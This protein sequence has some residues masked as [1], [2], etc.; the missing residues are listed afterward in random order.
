MCIAMPAWAIDEA[1][2]FSRE[3]IYITPKAEDEVQVEAKPETPP[4]SGDAEKPSATAK[5]VIRTKKEVMVNVRPESF[6]RQQGVFNL[7]PFMDAA[8]LMVVLAPPRPDALFAN[9]IFASVD[10]LFITAEGEIAQIVPSITP[11][12]LDETVSADRSVRALLFLR[13]GECERQDIRPADTVEHS[14]FRVKPTVLKLK[15]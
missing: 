13:A 3:T 8:G 15:P 4:E 10:V 1:V 11:S 9:N 6:L 2:S 5:P 14:L 12:D 7:Q